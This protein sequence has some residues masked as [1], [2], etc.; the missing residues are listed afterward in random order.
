MSKSLDAIKESDPELY[1]YMAEELLRQRNSLE[2][3]PSENFTSMAV[4]QLMGS[5]LTNKYSEGYPGKRYYGGN[6]YIDRIEDLAISRAKSLFGVEHANVQPYSGSPAN[7]EV[8][9]ALCNAGDTIMGQSLTSGGHLTHGD[10]ASATGKIF[11]SVQ[12]GAREDGYIDI[13]AARRLAIENRPKLIWIGST[14]YP[15]RLPFKE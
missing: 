2:M 12:Y 10:H 14:A 13:E 8:C 4:M 1:R 9:L 3:I 15:R 11:N 7:M 6:Q 5:V